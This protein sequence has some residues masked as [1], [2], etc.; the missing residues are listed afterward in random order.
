VYETL[1]TRAG[2]A[3]AAGQATII[4]AVHATPEERAA[5]E[6]LARA[7]GVPFAGHWLEASTERMTARISARRDDASDAT[8]EVLERQLTYDLGEVTWSRLDASGSIEST[9][10]AAR[11][12][13]EEAGLADCE[14]G[15]SVPS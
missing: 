9:L 4:D 8:A 11:R 14:P 3:L 7:N 15:A 5:V 10:A 12:M 1:L 2:E 6:A 13:F